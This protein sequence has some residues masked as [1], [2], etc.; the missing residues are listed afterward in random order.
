MVACHNRPRA[1]AILKARRNCLYM[2][3][4][5]RQRQGQHYRLG[6]EI[7]LFDVAAA[8]PR[9]GPSTE[10]TQLQKDLCYR[11]PIQG[12]RGGGKPKAAGWA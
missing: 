9:D 2:A 4:R 12:T 6:D 8:H 10:A 7:E 5:E 1:P 11:S 3:P